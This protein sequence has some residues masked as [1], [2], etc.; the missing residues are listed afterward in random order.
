MF[1]D[2]NRVLLGVNDRKSS[3]KISSNIKQ[4]NNF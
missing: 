1:S 4:I 3:R 2:N